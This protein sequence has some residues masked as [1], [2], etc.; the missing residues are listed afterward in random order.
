MSPVTASTLTEP[1]AVGVPKP[2]SVNVSEAPSTLVGKSESCTTGVSLVPRPTLTVVV[3]EGG[4]S[5]TP[6]TVNV[7]VPVATPPPVSRIV[8]VTVSVP[9]KSAAGVYSS[10]SPSVLMFAEPPWLGVPMLSMTKDSFAVSVA[11]LIKTSKSPVA[12][13]SVTENVSSLAIGGESA[14][15]TVTTTVAVDVSNPSETV[16]VNESVPIKSVGG[17]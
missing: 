6:A 16:Y 12:A 1:P 17:V 2:P 11:S 15:S 14:D 10:C 7:T 9:K 3:S 13:S 4:G 5:S 8:Y